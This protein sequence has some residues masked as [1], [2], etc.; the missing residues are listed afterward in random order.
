VKST[1]QE[2][3]KFTVYK[4]NDTFVSCP[5]KTDGLILHHYFNM[6]FIDKIMKRNV[7]ILS[8]TLMKNIFGFFIL[9]LIVLSCSNDKMQRGNNHGI[10]VIDMDKIEKADTLKMSQLFKNIVPIILETTQNSLIGEMINKLYAMDSILII[11][12]YSEAKSIFVFNREGKSLHKIGRIGRGP[13]EYASL[14]DFCID[15]VGKIIY[16]LDRAVDRIHKYEIYSGK[17]IKSIKLSRSLS[18]SYSTHGYIDYKSDALYFSISGHNFTDDKEGFLLHKIHPDSGGSIES[19]FDFREYNKGKVNMKRPF[20]YTNQKGLKYNTE[21]MNMIMSV[22][23][24]EVTPFLTFVSNEM[25]TKKDMENINIDEYDITVDQRI[26][27]LKKIWYFYDYFEGPDFIHTSFYKGNIPKSILY[28][29]Q[30]KQAKWVHRLLDDVIYVPSYKH[31]ANSENITETQNEEKT[32]AAE[33]YEIFKKKIMEGFEI[34]FSRISCQ[35]NRIMK[36]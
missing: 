14:D 22:S 27:I 24:N 16:V 26:W 23:E 5:V 18:D 11:A 6:E 17:H 33:E 7:F 28:Y 34:V 35:K 10:H 8:I 12:D 3:M 19:W 15:T 4:K 1:D 13:G 31:F 36:S 25:I 2:L 20:M 30:T 9:L 32:K 21:F 29:P